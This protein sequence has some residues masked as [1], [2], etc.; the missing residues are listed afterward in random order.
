MKND[1]QVIVV[2]GGHAGC[3]AALASA[4]MGLKTLLITMH[5]DKIGFMSC[6][7]AIGGVGK[8]QLVKEID[9]L[10]GEMARAADHSAIQFRMLNSSKGYAARSSRIQA[11]RAIYNRYMRNRILNQTRLKVL[12]D[13]AVDI[14]VENKVCRGVIT[15]SGMRINSSAVVITTGTFLNGLIHIGMKHVPGGR[16]G[17]EAAAG[18]SEGLKKLG[19]KV[20]RLKTGTTP[21]LDGRTIDFSGLKIQHGDKEIVPFSF[22]TKAIK[23]RQLPC[24]ITST[25]KKTHKIIRDNLDRSPLYTGKIKA[26]GVRYCPS[27]EDKI[28]RFA[29][30]DS[31]TIFL[32]PE[33]LKTHEYYPNG[34]STSL[35]A[36]VQEDIVRSIK[37]LEKAK[38]DIPGYGIEYDFVD[39]TE[40]YST[41]ETKKISGL[42][43]AGQINGTTGYEEA[44]SLGLMAGINAALKIQKKEPLVL[45]RSDAYIGVLIDDLTTKGTNEPYRMFTSRVEYRLL[46]REDNADTRLMEAGK[47][48]GL[49]DKKAY[50]AMKEKAHNVA[51]AEKMLESAKLSR[52]LKQSHVSYND[53]L[54]MDKRLPEL[55]YYEKVQVEVDM[56]YGGYI[57]RELA[58]VGKFGSLDRIKIPAKFD[59]SSVKGLSNEIKEKLAKMQ[60]YSLGQASRISG[61]TPAAMS[62]LMVKLHSN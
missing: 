1:F 12:E 40:L 33:G 52:V 38:T 51:E 45:K 3:E 6:N 23:C 21:R 55:S 43:M 54:K 31:H 48:L 59:Y 28:V 20:G 57:R 46:I 61:V 39:P 22:S 49:A 10:G 50:R 36:D 42:Y 5:L 11:D 25:N 16:I 19:F 58:S 44:A 34:I 13:E 24:Y 35:P 41:L 9:A 47:R 4:R 15:K 37:G 60:P 18:L 30:R 26:T 29:D 32:E 27:I 62:L 56:K 17:E 2:G 53:V 8:G 7:P 14:I